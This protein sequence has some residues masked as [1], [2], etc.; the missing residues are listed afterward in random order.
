M[1]LQCCVSLGAQPSDSV[2]YV[3]ILFHTHIFFFR[4]FS[5]IGR[6]QILSIVP[7]A[8][9]QVPTDYLLC[10]YSNVYKLIQGASEAYNI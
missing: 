4:F 10:L 7:C 3:C 6:Y 9:L 2:I 8:L 5:I 1:D